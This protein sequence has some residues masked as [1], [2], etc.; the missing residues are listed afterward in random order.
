VYFL[1]IPLYLDTVFSVV[2]C[3]PLVLFLVWLLLCFHL[4]MLVDIL[5]RIPVNLVDRFIVIFGGYF[6][7]RGILKMNREQ[8]TV[9]NE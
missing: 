4:P 1:K 9:I 7:A 6:A 3:L 2:I 8:L 5:S